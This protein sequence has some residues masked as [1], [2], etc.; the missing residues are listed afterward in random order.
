MRAALLTLLLV[1][2]PRLAAACPAC[3]AGQESAGK[4]WIMV[5]ALIA[6]PYAVGTIIFMAIRKNLGARGR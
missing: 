3:A 5:A 4:T 2:A 6:V 1:A